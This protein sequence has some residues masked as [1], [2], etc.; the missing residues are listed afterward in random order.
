MKHWIDGQVTTQDDAALRRI[1]PRDAELARL[2]AENERLTRE[3]AEARDTMEV[4]ACRVI[5]AG[6]D[7]RLLAAEQRESTLRE[8]L[9]GLVETWRE[10][11]RLTRDGIDDPVYNYPESWAGL[12]NRAD[13]DADDLATLLTPE[14]T[15]KE[16]PA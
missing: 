9:K 4:D 15:P 11:A 3:L 16:P 7:K 14:T 6:R 10:Y 12:A 13:A 8:K 1:D 5:V 2:K